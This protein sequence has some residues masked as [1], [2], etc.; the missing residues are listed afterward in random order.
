MAIN[1]NFNTEYK[2][3]LISQQ[4]FTMIHIKDA[5]KEEQELTVS[6][7]INH[8]DVIT[9]DS[10]TQKMIPVFALKIIQD[11]DVTKK[12]FQ[13]CAMIMVIGFVMSI[14]N[15][16]V[17]VIKTLTENIVSTQD[18]KEEESLSKVAFVSVK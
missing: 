10:I 18:V 3:T 7:T 1:V 15:L 17:S 12:D 16:N 14:I 9:M 13:K 2:I 5:F 8:Q 11:K 4:L 6:I